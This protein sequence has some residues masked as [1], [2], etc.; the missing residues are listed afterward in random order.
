MIT[1][2]HSNQAFGYSCKVTLPSSTRGTTV[3]DKVRSLPNPNWLLIKP[4]T[5]GS[6]EEYLKT[7]I[8]GGKES[9]PHTEGMQ[10]IIIS[11]N[12]KTSFPLKTVLNFLF[13]PGKVQ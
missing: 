2:I 12:R 10:R 3:L 9:I 11:D 1:G 6:W 13:G 5:V 8:L 7:I 4:E